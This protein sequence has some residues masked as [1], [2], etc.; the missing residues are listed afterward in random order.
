MM[1]P[2][3]PKDLIVLVAD[4]NQEH[5]IRGILSRHRSLGVPELSADVY[6]HP[7]RDP[8]CLLRG[9]E[10]LR[11]FTRQYAHALLLLDREGSGREDS[12]PRTLEEEIE[13]RLRSSGWGERAAAVVLEPDLEVWVWSDS[14]IVAAT[15]GWAGRTPPLHQWLLAQGHLQEGQTKPSR[16]KKALEEALRIAQKHRSSAIFSELA[17]KV[18][19]ARC[20][21]AA[22]LKL[23]RTLRTWFGPPN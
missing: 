6:A 15:L 12:P 2:P 22:F 17:R 11:P 10:F 23:K 9:H 5:A 19:M 13:S 7:H 3:P 16:P 1:D 14:P 21:D 8:G 20:A 18:S 4:K